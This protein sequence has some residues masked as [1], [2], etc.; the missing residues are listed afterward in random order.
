MNARVAATRIGI[1]GCGNISAVYFKAGK[2]LDA[3]DLA[4]CADL[5]PE[6]ADRRGTEFGV[7]AVP[8]KDLLGDPSIRVVVNLT[9]PGAHAEV[10]MAALQAGKDVYSE[11][12]LAVNRADGRKQLDEAK[13]RDLRIGCAPDTFMGVGIQTCRKLIDDGVI[14]TP[15][16]AAAFL[17]GHGHESWHPAPE[18]YYKPGGGP[19]FD[20]GPYYLT[21][22]VNLLGPIRRV[23][24]STRMT[25]GE[26]LITSEPKKGTKIKVEVPTHIAGVM[27]FANGAVGTIVTSFDIWAH[28]MPCIEIYGSEG[29]L[30]VPDP[31]GFDGPVKV[32][33]PGDNEWQDVPHIA[34]PAWQSRGLGVADMVLA[35]AEK[36][37]HRASGELAFHVLDVMQALHEASDSGRYAEMG[38]TCAR[39]EPVP[40]GLVRNRE[41]GT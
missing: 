38:S 41:G 37:P 14:G 3:L 22:L 1:I 2:T 40:A 34:G 9:V 11:K 31:N 39:P 19:M 16:A 17:M 18:F 5:N 4:A 28:R 23:C 7:K 26:R 35:T 21:A 30:S 32:R 6:A 33:K 25:F 27:D 15:V 24:G 13:A 8:V 36:R 29:S 10:A 20:M 12:P